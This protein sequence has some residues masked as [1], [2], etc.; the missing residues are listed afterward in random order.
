MTVGSWRFRLLLERRARRAQEQDGEAVPEIGA[1]PER[2]AEE[3][4]D[5]GTGPALEPEPDREGEPVLAV[6]PPPPPEPALEP[7]PEPEPAPAVVPL[8]LRDQTPRTWN[9][10]ELERL[11]KALNGEAAATEERTLLLLHLRQFADPSGDLP[12]EFDPLV[13]EAFGGNLAAL[14]R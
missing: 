5:S 4:L 10:W 9:L 8:G 2:M 3:E 11:A 6:A 1:E 12:V 14:P 7:E 13:R